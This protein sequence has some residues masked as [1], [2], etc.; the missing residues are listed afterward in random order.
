[1]ADQFQLQLFAHTVHGNHVHPSQ[2][3]GVPEHEG[4]DP[5]PDHWQVQVRDEQSHALA[6]SLTFVPLTH[7]PE[8]KV[9]SSV[10][11]PHTTHTLV[12]LHHI[13]GFHPF[14][15]VQFHVLVV[16]QAV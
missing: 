15:H 1:M 3:F 5:P 11:P 12:I 7:D 14:T 2:Q 6:L 9:Q 10:I 16:L 13:A 8:V 4:L